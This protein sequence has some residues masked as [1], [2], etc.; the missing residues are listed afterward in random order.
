MAWATLEISDGDTTASLLRGED[1][2]S[3]KSWR[4]AIAQYEGGGVWQASPFVDGKRLVLAQWDDTI[5]TFN[6]VAASGVDEDELIAFTQDLRRLLVKAVHY[7]ASD[8]T[9]SPVYIAAGAACETNTRYAIVKSWGTPDEGNPYGQP[10]MNS[11]GSVMTDIILN[12]NRGHWQ[13]T[14]PGTGECQMISGL[15]IGNEQQIFAP[16]LAADDAY[17]DTRDSTIQ[18]SRGVNFMGAADVGSYHTGIR[19]RNVTLE[20]AVEINRAFVTFIAILPQIGE[21]NLLIF[22]ENNAAPAA[23]TT[24]ANF[25]GRTPTAASVVWNSL[26]SWVV[27]AQFLSVDITP[28][29]QEIVDLGG[30]ASGNDLVLF[31]FNNFSDTT[32][33]RSGAS[34]DHTFYNPPQL[35]VISDVSQVGRGATCEREVFVANK[36]NKS[37][38]THIYRDDAGVWSANLVGESAYNLLS[39]PALV[40]DAVYFGCE[41]AIADTGPFCSLIFDLAT[42]STTGNCLWE[43]WN[44]AAWFA[45][46]IATICDNTSPTQ[47][48]NPFYNDSVQSV[49]WPQ[50]NDWA[51]RNLATDGGP[52]VTGWFVRCR[53]FVQM[54]E[55]VQQNRP[56]YSALWPYVTINSA[57]IGGEIPALAEIQVTTKSQKTGGD[58]QVRFPNL[59]SNKIMAALRSVSRGDIFSPF[60]N[61]Q[62][63]QNPEGITIGGPLAPT[64]FQADPT[65]ATGLNATFNPAGAVAEQSSV[66]V[67][68]TRE[69]ARQYQ[70]RYRMM[71]RGQQDGGDADSLFIQIEHRINEWMVLS[72]SPTRQFVSTATDWQLLDFGEIT[73]PGFSD[74]NTDEVVT[75]LELDILVQC[76][77]AVAPG[78]L[79]LYDLIL[80][81]IDEWVGEFKDTA[82]LAQG[83]IGGD[84]VADG[85]WRYLSIDSVGYPKKSL[86]A[87]IKT[88]DLDVIHRWS[89]ATNGPAILQANTEQRLFF[90]SWRNVNTGTYDEDQFF[91]EPWVGHN[92][93]VNKAQRYL[94]MRGAG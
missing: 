61:L 10:F 47:F 50:P 39:N 67:E 60:I 92:I 18:A 35:T 59:Y 78:D 41:S 89:S 13:G 48:I 75:G 43:Y 77:D 62:N 31:F 57:N 93:V 6:L 28:V 8:R 68:F 73:L 24:F 5:E 72:Q 83:W 9:G 22:G 23:F 34:S 56:V 82:E 16:V 71:L 76:T 86:R 91:S 94:S 37:Q 65:T 12:L 49:H 54:T 81:P 87:P 11:D 63:E 85:V 46:T 26:P 19:F 36:A 52:A 7:W 79:V 88:T 70:G 1:G 27:G 38:L 14:P 40:G 25:M 51:E 44:G 4:P 80:W 84:R 53:V 69:A 45:F 30:W 17:V 32:S 64:T 42:V 21:T 15:G 33:L 2:Y 66:T 29:I 3:L 20:N 74:I 55:I 90:L 58:I